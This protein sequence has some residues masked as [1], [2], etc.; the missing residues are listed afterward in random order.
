MLYLLVGSLEAFTLLAAPHAGTR[1]PGITMQLHNQYN[2]NYPRQPSPTFNSQIGDN[3]YTRVNKLNTMGGDAA[4]AE[5]EYRSQPSP[6]WY[7][8]HGDNTWGRVGK[9]NTMGGDAPATEGAYRSQPSATWYPQ[10]GDNTWDRQAN[11]NNKEMPAG[12]PNVGGM[13][14]HRPSA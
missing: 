3:V 4:A 9:L 11:L 7:A 6:T 2:Q 12:R 13:W 14:A 1:A 8:Q 5:G 10:H